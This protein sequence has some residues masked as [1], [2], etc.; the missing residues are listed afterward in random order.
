MFC[1]VFLLKGSGPLGSNFVSE[2]L[3]GQFPSE[4]LYLQAELL[5]LQQQV[6]SLQLQQVCVHDHQPPLLLAC[7]AK[8]HEN[9]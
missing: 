6:S 2:S 9:H 4:D 1:Q 7:T 3:L 8:P 5:P